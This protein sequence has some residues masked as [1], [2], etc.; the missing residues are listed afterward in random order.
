MATPQR[1]RKLSPQAFRLLMLSA[2][3]LGV[4]ARLHAQ[5]IG[6]DTAPP[7][8]QTQAA[9]PVAAPAE[10]AVSVRERTRLF[11]KADTNHD[12]KLSP[13]EAASLPGVGKKFAEFDRDHDGVEPPGIPRRARPQHPRLT[14]SLGP[15]HGWERH[16]GLHWKA[17]KSFAGDTP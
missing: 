16:R 3:F 1:R 17:S 7:P 13:A 11:D 2:S 10:S 4:H 14:S 8:A 15:A 5:V 12:G 9:P 6:P